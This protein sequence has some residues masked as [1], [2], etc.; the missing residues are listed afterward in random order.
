MKVIP[1]DKVIYSFNCENKMQYFVENGETFWVE[2]DD[3]YHGQIQDSSVLRT[4]IDISITDCSVGPI[5]V[6]DARPG[7]VLCVEVIAIQFADHGVM[8]TSPGL[9]ILGDKITEGNTKLYRLK[10]AL[11]ISQKIL[12]FL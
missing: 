6:K 9:G 4:D 8:V 11:L 1:K 12:K 3:C 5:G 2:T 10:M 7:D